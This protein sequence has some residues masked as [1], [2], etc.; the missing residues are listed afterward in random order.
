MDAE[1]IVV[2]DP[3][4]CGVPTGRTGELL[5]LMYGI[6]VGIFGVNGFAGKEFEPLAVNAHHLIPHTDQ[7]HL[8]PPLARVVDGLVPK[9]V[10]IKSTE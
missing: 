10:E 1:K 2:V 9:A 3:N 6:F 8:D 4:L 7:M 5:K